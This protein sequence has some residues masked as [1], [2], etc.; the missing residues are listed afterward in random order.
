MCQKCRGKGRE[1]ERHK[2]PDQDLTR[3]EANKRWV[4]KVE[5]CL[6]T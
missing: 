3:I 6:N 4:I 2:R 1:R 5:M